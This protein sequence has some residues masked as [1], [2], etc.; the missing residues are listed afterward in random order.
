MSIFEK[1]AWFS[2]P[3]HSS[4]YTT[5]SCMEIR[6]F[7]VKYEWTVMLISMESSLIQFQ[8]CIE[9]KL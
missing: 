5:E 3:I 6:A 1:S 7:K 8:S 9:N 2:K 4:E